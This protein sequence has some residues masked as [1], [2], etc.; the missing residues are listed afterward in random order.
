[1]IAFLALFVETTDLQHFRVV[2][3]SVR[4]E[5]RLCTGEPHQNLDRQLGGMNSR[6]TGAESDRNSVRNEIGQ[7]RVSRPTSA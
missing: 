6:L 1:M 4:N 3:K 5:N 7:A 2:Q